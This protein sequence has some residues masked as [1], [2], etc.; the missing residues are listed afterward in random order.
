MLTLQ[1]Y[2]I[3]DRLKEL[4]KYNGFQVAPAELE[5]MLLKHPKVA[6]VAV[7]G[8]VSAERATELPRAYVVPAPNAGQPEAVSQEIV[9]WVAEN[10][11]VPLKGC[12][13]NWPLIILR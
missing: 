13:R 4:I 1:I 2:S 3:V 9:D 7:I 6:D 5:A 12:V 8:V 10:V 11:G